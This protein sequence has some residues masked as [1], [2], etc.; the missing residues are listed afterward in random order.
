MNLTDYTSV[1]DYTMTWPTFWYVVAV[2]G[3][4]VGFWI[5]TNLRRRPWPPT[6]KGD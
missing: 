3:F 5:Y 2:A 4:V 1:T 6:G